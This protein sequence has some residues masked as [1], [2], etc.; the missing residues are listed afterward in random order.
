MNSEE[1][2][3]L[4]RQFVEEV[5]AEWGSTDYITRSFS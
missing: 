2:K 1:N 5:D 4:V 3:V